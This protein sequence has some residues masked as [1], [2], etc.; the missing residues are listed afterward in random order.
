MK[1][2][3]IILSGAPGTG[4]TTIAW[5][6]K[7]KLDPTTYID[8]GW[9]REWHLMRDWSNA[10][11]EEEDFAFENLVLVLKNYIK[12]GYKN[13]ILTDL[14][15]DKILKLAEIFKEREVVIFTLIM[16]DEAELAKRILSERDS[17]FKDVPKALE[18]QKGYLSRE[19]LPNEHRLDN[20]HTDPSKT[21]E[22]ILDIL[23]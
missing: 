8:F 20:N 18:Y 15:D 22:E 7:E 1:K 3:L 10:N 9:L 23:G 6:L 13:I 21:V 12:H 2:D 17:G 5:K 11:Q 16:S 14:Q 4:K 19:E